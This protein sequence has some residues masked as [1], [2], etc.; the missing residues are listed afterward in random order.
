MGAVARLGINAEEDWVFISAPPFK[1]MPMEA[2]DVSHFLKNVHSRGVQVR[3]GKHLQH[4]VR[5]GLH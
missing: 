5:A 1:H 2:N 3:I 4:A